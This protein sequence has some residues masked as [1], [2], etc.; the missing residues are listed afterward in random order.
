MALYVVVFC[1]QSDHGQEAGHV[2]WRFD[3]HNLWKISTTKSL[4]GN[5][6]FHIVLYMNNSKNYILL[7]QSMLMNHGYMALT[8]YCG[9]NQSGSNCTG[10]IAASLLTNRPMQFLNFEKFSSC[11][12]I[13]PPNNSLYTTDELLLFVNIMFMVHALKFEPPW[14]QRCMTLP[15]NFIIDR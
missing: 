15:Q 7:N 10:C 13:F 2:Q 12:C 11:L 1:L 8:S 9:W 3:A 14:L 5:P 6:Q 4:H